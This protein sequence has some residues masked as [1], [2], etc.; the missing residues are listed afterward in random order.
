MCDIKS[1]QRCTNTNISQKLLCEPQ[2]EKVEAVLTTDLTFFVV[3]VKKTGSQNQ[4]K[5]NKEKSVFQ[6]RRTAVCTSLQNLSK[7]SHLECQEEAENAP[8]LPA[9]Q[10][11]CEEAALGQEQAV[12][13]HADQYVH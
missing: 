10:S 9:R 5:T 7:S 13:H 8:W 1:K 3:V 12:T 2:M 4:I 11:P 6:E